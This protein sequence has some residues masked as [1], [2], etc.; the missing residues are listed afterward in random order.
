MKPAHAVSA[1]ALS[2]VG[3]LVALPASAAPITWNTDGAT[4]IATAYGNT[5]TFSSGGTTM[6]ARAYSTTGSGSTLQTACLDMFGSYG[7]GVVSR[8]E[9]TNPN[10]CDTGVPNHSADN[11]GSVDGFLLSFTSAVQL[12]GVRTGW[13][14][15]DSDFSVLYYTGS[16]APGM[17]YSL[18][19]M[20]SNGWSLLRN[21]N[22]S[23]SDNVSYNLSSSSSNV[24]RYWYVSAYSTSFGAGLDGGDDYFKLR[25]VSAETVVPE[26]GTLALLGL[27][28]AGVGL[29]RRRRS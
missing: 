18:G 22:G 23:S 12:T 15:G 21:V 2:A 7:M 5:Q 9:D 10:P 27:G 24:S 13:V 4:S 11:Q 26:P 1:I 3:V 20:L 29:A 8:T 14:E 16:S 6:T 19:N 25:S 28:L 17:N